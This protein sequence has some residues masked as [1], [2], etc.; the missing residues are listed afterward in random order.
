MRIEPQAWV[1]QHM[2]QF[3]PEAFKAQRMQE[4][5]DIAEYRAR[6]LKFIKGWSD[7]EIRAKL[8]AKHAREVEEA[9]R[10]VA[11]N[12]QLM[13]AQASAIGRRYVSPLTSLPIFSELGDRIAI[14]PIAKP[15]PKKRHWLARLFG[16]R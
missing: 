5:K 15:L 13:E 3:S 2:D 10:L 1:F 16:R 8:Q 6:H 14:T 7:P 9:Q 4:L 11:A 12:P